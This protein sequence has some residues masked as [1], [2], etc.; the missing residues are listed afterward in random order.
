MTQTTLLT[1][2][3]LSLLLLT[4][5]IALKAARSLP[6]KDERA[7]PPQTLDTLRT[8]PEVTSRGAW[9][10]RAK[11]I[12]EQVLASCGLWPLPKKTPLKA[13][14]FDR[15]ERE[16]YSVEKVY[17]QS[18]PGFYVAGNLYRPLSKGK[19]PFPAVL[20]PHGHWAQ[21]RLN[22]TKEGSIAARCISFARQGMVAFSWDMTGYND[23]MQLGPHRRIATNRLNQLWNI[24]LMGLQTWNSIRALDF[25]ESLPDVDKS[26]LAC[27][28]ESGGGTQTFML[29][30]AET[31]LA[32]QAPVVMVSHSMQG[33]C[34]CENAPGLRVD[35]SNMEIA[36]VPAPRPQI[37]VAASGDWTKTTMTI[38]GPSIEK[39]YNLFG[40]AD[41]L[42]YVRFEFD[43]NYNQTSRE[44][45]YGFFNK[46]L[47]HGNS[48]DAVKEPAYEKEPNE[49]LLV[50]QD[51]QLP[52]DAV[53]E[54]QL[55]ANIIKADREQLAALTPKTKKAA[56]EFRATLMPLWQ[57][58][59]QVEL[60]ESDLIV[61]RDA[62]KRLGKYRSTTMAIGRAGKHDRLPALM[63]TPETERYEVLCLLVHDKGKSAYLDDHGEPRGLAKE[64]LDHNHTVILVDTFLTGELADEKASAARKPF[65][66][67]FTTYN[68]TDLQERVQDIITVCA[69][70]QTH[71][72]GRRVVVFGQGRAGLWAMLAAPI[73]SGVVADCDGL[74]D[75]DD[76]ALL[77]KELF[78]PGLRRMGG[79]QTAA[80]LAAP[81]PLLTYNTGSGFSTDL[82]RAAYKTESATPKFEAKA[83]KMSDREIAEWIGKMR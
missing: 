18:Y 2:S 58:T 5:P 48:T 68:R 33:G 3:L 9:G 83:D 60:P 73:A 63:I 7:G 82:I 42:L 65:S 19:G 13:E 57:H 62:E 24:N 70:G 25:L 6:E 43:H 61:E 80:A 26:R 32:A 49:K 69:V 46:W 22:D 51:R 76:A 23:M 36:A 1:R 10:E 17:F 28:G 54:A 20:N 64:L 59:L 81:R 72:K 27:T 52:S 77:S 45:V 12:R 71:S 44:A 4:S 30:A 78:A 29:G 34:L 11:E 8:F 66:S 21:G 55:I 15:T 31:R 79:F 39:I 50:W 14:I 53:N 74:Q 37:L 56:E 35:Y 67:F 40:A 75:N 41:H 38:E 16:G 47:L